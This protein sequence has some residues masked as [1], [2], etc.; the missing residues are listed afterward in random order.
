[1]DI[2][3]TDK[4]LNLLGIGIT[5]SAFQMA[6]VQKIKMLPL[7]N[8]KYKIWLL[9]L[10]VSFGVGIPFAIFFF[11]ISVVDSIWVSLF[12]FIGAPSLY[13]ALKKQNMINYKPESATIK[14]TISIP[15]SHQINKEIE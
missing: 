7:F 10:F 14:D 4:L 2:F 3:V 6:L 9:N 13:A 15:V 8:K 5:F 11:G 12:G 1:M